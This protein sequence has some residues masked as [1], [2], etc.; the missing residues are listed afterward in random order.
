MQLSDNELW[1]YIREDVPYFDLTT[2]LLDVTSKDITLT[3]ATRDEIIVACT[4]EAARIAQLLGC[5]VVN[6]VKS[7]TLIK[8]GEIL[9]EIKGDYENVHQAWRVSQILLEHACGLATEADKMLKAV[10]EVNPY[11]ELL[12]TR[13]SY[14]FAKKFTI[15]ALLC[16]GVLPHRLG[17]SETLLVFEQH[18]MLYENQESFQKAMKVLKKRCVEKKLVIESDNFED[19][20]AMLQLGADV[21]QMDKCSLQTLAIVVNYKN[22]HFPNAMILAAGGINTTNCVEY[23]KS[24]VDALVTSA[25]YHVKMADL[26]SQIGVL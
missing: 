5:E 11:C 21:I 3:I 17:L 15:R 2:H 8:K 19:A 6:F 23:A 24:G 18:R 10:K 1:E 4:E 9:L 16:G 12:V 25:L 7:K 13:K 22:Q 26:K 20:K 14:P